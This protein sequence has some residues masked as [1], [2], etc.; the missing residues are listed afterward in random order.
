MEVNYEST[1]GRKSGRKSRQEVKAGSQGRKSR[2][3]V[4]VG[5]QESAF[6]R[7]EVRFPDRKS[8]SPTAQWLFGLGRRDKPAVKAAILT[9]TSLL[10]G[11]RGS[12]LE[13]A[14]GLEV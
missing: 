2:Q 9:S 11:S 6:G 3:E 12:S 4:K 10:S 1:L 8:G 14:G 7:Q 5:S 13:A